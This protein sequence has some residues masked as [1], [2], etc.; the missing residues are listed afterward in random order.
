MAAVALS[1][2]NVFSGESFNT[3]FWTSSEDQAA[4]L[5]ING[6][7]KGMLPYLTAGPDCDNDELKKKT[8]M[9]KLP[10]AT[11]DVAVKD[12][13][14]QTLYGEELTIR[15]S[16][17][18]LTLSNKT[19]FKNGGSRRVFKDSCLIEELYYRSPN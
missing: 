10:S 12:S 19:A 8:L 7:N 11:Y 6:E 16:N 17:G 14:G 18:S 3:Y 15:R 1:A 4:Y 5:Y 13:L 9:I 2:C